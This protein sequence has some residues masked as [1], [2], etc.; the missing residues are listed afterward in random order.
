[1]LRN[2]EALPMCPLCLDSTWPYQWGN[3]LSFCRHV[4]LVTDH[5][6][7]QAFPE[8]M[9]YEPEE[10]WEIARSFWFDPTDRIRIKILKEIIFK[11]EHPIIG[12]FINLFKK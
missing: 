7:L 3:T 1:M 8:I 4:Y 2:M 9:A 11:M 6:N 12:W 10:H 5:I